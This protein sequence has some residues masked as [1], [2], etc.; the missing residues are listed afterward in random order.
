MQVSNATHE[1]GGAQKP[2]QCAEK[3]LLP[4]PLDLLVLQSTPTLPQ[5]LQ[6]FTRTRWV[7]KRL[8]RL[9]FDQ[10]KPPLGDLGLVLFRLS[11]PRRVNV[12]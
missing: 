4:S 10:R 11:D 9:S 2:L 7:G 3:H 1:S 6:Y 12:Q 5:M 8:P